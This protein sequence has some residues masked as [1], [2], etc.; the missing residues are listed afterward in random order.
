MEAQKEDGKGMAAAMAKRTER[1]KGEDNGS[2]YMD[3]SSRSRAARS[4]PR[5]Q[6][7]EERESV[8]EQVEVQ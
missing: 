2:I 1:Q 8:E 7:E 6:E 4:T 5:R 3:K